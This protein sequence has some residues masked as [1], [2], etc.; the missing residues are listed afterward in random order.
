MFI[1]LLITQIGLKPSL[2]AILDTTS[3]VNE[4]EIIFTSEEP[5]KLWM[6]SEP[7]GG[8]AG[9]IPGDTVSLCGDS[10]KD[11]SWILTEPLFGV[12]GGFLGAVLIELIS[13][14][15]LAEE[16]ETVVFPVMF[17][18]GV[19]LGAWSAGKFIE[20]EKGSFGA[21]FFGAL[22][23]MLIPLVWGAED[24]MFPLSVAGS[25]VFYRIMLK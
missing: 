24:I 4:T 18:S 9:E 5:N 21:A 3:P 23:G 8:L 19:S 7:L 20:K 25:V 12:I 15:D 22:V 10:K 17:S 1:L 11:Y 2:F 14:G 13:N 6:I 16:S